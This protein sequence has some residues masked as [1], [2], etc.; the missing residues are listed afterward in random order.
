MADAKDNEDEFEADS[1]LYDSDGNFEAFSAKVK[2]SFSFKM[3]EGSL[4][5]PE[6]EDNP[7]FIRLR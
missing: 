2:G 7:I 3:K 5:C 1:D 6:L 4:R